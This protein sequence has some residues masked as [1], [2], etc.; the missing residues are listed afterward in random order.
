MYGVEE[1]AAGHEA[2]APS[3]EAS[4]VTNRIVLPGMETLDS[5][6]CPP[7]TC[8][9]HAPDGTDTARTGHLTRKQRPFHEHSALRRLLHALPATVHSYDAL[10]VR[11]VR[12]QSRCEPS[13]GPKRR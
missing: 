11:C 2:G 5:T 8:G 4:A 9:Y 12:A 13:R 3:A 10:A 7:P 6:A 1:Q